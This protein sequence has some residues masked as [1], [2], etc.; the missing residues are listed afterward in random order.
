MNDVHGLLR[1]PE[2]WVPVAIVVLGGAML[3]LLMVLHGFG[4]DRIVT[5]YKRNAERLRQRNRRPSLAVFAFAT[6]ILGMLV[7]HMIELWLW[8]G[9]LWTGGLVKDLHV[10]MYFAAN[11]Y[12]TLGMGNMVLPHTWH[13]MSPMIAISGLF[14]FAWTTSE[15]FNIVGDQHDLMKELA[16]KRDGKAAS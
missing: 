3:V 7:L 10:S 8:G 6:T 5:R 4:L 13:E 15:L 11:A 1:V 16:E 12:T 2:D 9:L 14:A